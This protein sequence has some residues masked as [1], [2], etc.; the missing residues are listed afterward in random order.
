MI[1]LKGIVVAGLLA[2]SPAAADPTSRRDLEA[3]AGRIIAHQDA[4]SRIWP[5]FWP[6][7]QPF[8]IHHP[9]TGAVFAGG[10]APAGPEFRPGPLP[11]AVSS[12]E[13]DYPSGIANTVALRYEGDGS[14]LE[15][16]FHEQF[17]DYQ[18]EA[19]R[20]IGAGVPEFVDLSLIPDRAGFAAAAE[21]ERRVLVEALDAR[22]QEQRSRLAA[23]YLGLRR[24]RLS[25]LDP[26]IAI[27][28]AYREWSEGT[29]EYVGVLGGA[30]V[31]GRPGRARTCI[32]EALRRDLNGASGGFSVNW[33]RW[34]AYGVGAALAWL[35]DDLGV[36]W[37]TDIESGVPLDVRLAQALGESA[38]LP[39]AA[40]LLERYGYR[41]L[42]Q[43]MEGRLDRAPP[44]PS[45]QEEFLASAPV[46]LA[47]YIAV[48]PARASEL[49]MSF[50]ATG[51]TPLPGEVLALT[52]VGYLT[53]RIGDV[54]LWVSNRP[55]LTEMAG[56]SARQIVMLS[57]FDG[58]EELAAAAGGDPAPLNLDLG[59]LRLK[60]S[61]ATVEVLE[62]E[63]R[64]HLAP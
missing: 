29:A 35:L 3:A 17:H 62:K 15:T 8:I 52:D 54:E 55:V 40:L 63:I 16:L 41:R 10:A 6:D 51:M 47:I 26:T 57:S 23:R 19:F 46:R 12:Y 56:T 42:R 20:W 45:S 50:Q 2:A 24:Q 59:W 7:G 27:A 39:E 32:V 22:S 28:E 60:A 30:I 38:E 4:L 43:E 33:F 11:G 44:A 37:R 21:I 48:P 18:T 13:L 14:D 53:V 31:A 1:R 36:D 58:L 34:R 9:G 64:L 25:A 61:A 5:G 49:E